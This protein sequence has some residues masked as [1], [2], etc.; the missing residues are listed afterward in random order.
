[1]LLV[2]AFLVPPLCRSLGAGLASAISLA[3]GEAVGETVVGVA[4]TG[5]GLGTGI[6]AAAIAVVWWY[7]CD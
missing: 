1:M 4:L 5:F 6:G 3:G 7:Y 2:E